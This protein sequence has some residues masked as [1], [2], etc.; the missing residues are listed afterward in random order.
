MYL[1]IFVVLVAALTLSGCDNLGTYLGRKDATGAK[2][3]APLDGVLKSAVGSNDVIWS[4]PDTNQTIDVVFDDKNKEQPFKEYWSTAPSIQTVQSNLS[5]LVPT[6]TSP[7]YRYFKYAEGVTIP[8]YK[9]EEGVNIVVDNKFRG[10]D[11][12]KLLKEVAGSNG[13]KYDTAAPTN[14]I[15]VLGRVLNPIKS[16]WSANPEIYTL[17]EDYLNNNS[18]DEDPRNKVN[19]NTGLFSQYDPKNPEQMLLDV[20]RTGANSVQGPP[21]AP[22]AVLLVLYQPANYWQ[23]ANGNR[24]RDNSANPMYFDAYYSIDNWNLFTNKNDGKTQP[25]PD[26]LK[27]PAKF[28]ICKYSSTPSTQSITLKSVGDYRGDEDNMNREVILHTNCNRVTNIGHCC[29]VAIEKGDCPEEPDEL[30]RDPSANGD[31]KFTLIDLLADQNYSDAALDAS[32]FTIASA[33]NQ[34]PTQPDINLWT[35][36]EF[37]EMLKNGPLE[38]SRPNDY[39]KPLQNKASDS[40]SP[41]SNL[42]VPEWLF[43]KAAYVANRNGIC[44]GNINCALAHAKY[45]VSFTNNKK[46]VFYHN[47]TLVYN[48]NI[49]ELQPPSDTGAHPIANTDT[50]QW[51]WCWFSPE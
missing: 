23:T 18:K 44:G 32:K 12:Q 31:V 45:K 7:S 30:S 39:S 36:Y 22:P 51:P 47:R 16:R 19:G 50:Y 37:I 2:V 21:K 1:R 14:V 24:V 48:K 34:I 43:S 42:R 3:I 46:N 28:G 6:N 4:T 17:R 29:N 40:F 33:N 8:E 15:P 20:D 11:S 13:K 9:V 35:K 26:T 5:K 27:S 10:Q 25:S 49:Y 38:F 41:K